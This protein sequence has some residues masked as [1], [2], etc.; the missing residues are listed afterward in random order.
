MKAIAYLIAAIC[1]FSSQAVAQTVAI[2]VQSSR[3][4]DS[5]KDALDD[6]YGQ[7]SEFLGEQYDIMLAIN[8]Y[9][10]DN[11]RLVDDGHNYKISDYWAKPSET[12]KNGGDCEDLAI[13]KMKMLLNAGFDHDNMRIM[14]VRDIIRQAYHA[15][16]VVM[17]DEAY[18]LDS[19]SNQV[20]KASEVKGYVPVISINLTSRMIYGYRIEKKED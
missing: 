9:V 10:N 13:L 19:P 17:I 14:I 5:L 6:D 12:E 2:P 1:L 3:Y 20:F 16:L 11:V 15:V 7:G 4:D 8:R 18:I